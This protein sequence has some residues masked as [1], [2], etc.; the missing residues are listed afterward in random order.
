[1]ATGSSEL[2]SFPLRRLPGPRLTTRQHFVTVGSLKVQTERRTHARRF[3]N[4]SRNAIHH[5]HYYKN[6]KPTNWW[7]KAK[8]VPLNLKIFFKL[9]S[10][11]NLWVWGR[12]CAGEFFCRQTARMYWIFWCICK[13]QLLNAQRGKELG[14]SCGMESSNKQSRVHPCLYRGPKAYRFK[15]L[16]VSVTVWP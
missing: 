3:Q 1:M 15:E 7:G 10:L 8:R 5:H 2:T 14:L 11:V 6:E 13:L 4:N 12:R 16:L 9:S